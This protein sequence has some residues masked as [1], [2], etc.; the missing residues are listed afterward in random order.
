MMFLFV[1]F[2]SSQQYRRT[3]IPIRFRKSKARLI[4]RLDLHRLSAP[5]IESLRSLSR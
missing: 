5:M 3:F 1:A 4:A 2:R